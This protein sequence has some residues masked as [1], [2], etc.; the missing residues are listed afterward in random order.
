[1][2]IKINKAI[3]VCFDLIIMLNNECFLLAVDIK[4]KNNNNLNVK[5][6]KFVNFLII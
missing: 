2:G 1:M 6:C 4:I 5:E 3:N